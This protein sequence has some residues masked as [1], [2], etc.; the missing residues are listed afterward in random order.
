MKVEKNL[1]EFLNTFVWIWVLLLLFLGV[2]HLHDYRLGKT[3]IVCV[4]SVL[5]M[6][7]IWA[8]FVLM[9]A[10]TGNLK[11]FIQGLA[12]ESWMTIKYR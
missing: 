6:A 11:A 1:F 12:L 2:K 4:L 9:F 8:L 10:L 5:G 3:I 7:L